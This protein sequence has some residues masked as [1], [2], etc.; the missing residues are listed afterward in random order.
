MNQS[1]KVAIGFAAVA[2]VAALA[3]WGKFHQP[4][5]PRSYVPRRSGTVTFTKDIAPIIFKNCSSCHRPGQSAPFNLLTYEDV[6]KH[7]RQIVEVTSKRY[8]PPWLPEPGY[9]EFIG[10]RV[11]DERPNRPHPAVGV[12]RHIARDGRFAA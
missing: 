6:K 5:A 1:A 4:N 11:Y 10:A 8:M 7:A 2:A 9:G 3:L 12:G